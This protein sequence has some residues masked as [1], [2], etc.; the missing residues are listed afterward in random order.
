M[1]PMTRKKLPSERKPQYNFIDLTG[2]RFGRLLIISRVENIRNKTGLHINESRAAWLCKCDCGKEKI[3]TGGSLR[4]GLSESCG[5]LKKERC[6][7]A[8]HLLSGKNH[9]RYKPDREKLYFSRIIESYK[10]H[11]TERGLEWNLSDDEAITTMKRPCCYCGQE[12][13]N[14]RNYSDVKIPYSGIDRINNDTGYFPTNIVPCCKNCNRAKNNMSKN[15][16]TEWVKRV[17]GHTVAGP[18]GIYFQNTAN[19]PEEVT[20]PISFWLQNRMPPWEIMS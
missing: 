9:W 3:V 14:V 16:F 11:A 13:S 17:Y 2:Q 4:R 15:E 18:Q 8:L 12:P 10:T 19:G 7:A 1:A 6:A 5:C 20:M